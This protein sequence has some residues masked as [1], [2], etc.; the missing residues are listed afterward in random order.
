MS[1]S[2]LTSRLGFV[3][4]E[5]GIGIEIKPRASI[6]G[7]IFSDAVASTTPQS[8]EHY[9]YTIKFNL[10]FAAF[11]LIKSFSNHQDILDGGTF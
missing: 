4:I 10:S 2:N 6:I 7:R 8:A 9:G 11:S 3:S 1:F 5:I